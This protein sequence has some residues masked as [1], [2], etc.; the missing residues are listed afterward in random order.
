MV[1]NKRNTYNLEKR[2][3]YFCIIDM[4]FLPYIRFLSIKASMIIVAIWYINGGFKKAFTKKSFNRFLIFML[5]SFTS[6]LLGIILNYQMH[7]FKYILISNSTILLITWFSYLY[8]YYYRYNFRRYEI[9]LEKI[10]IL[11][12]LFAFMSAVL[13][14][15]EPQLFYNIRRF[16]TLGNEEITFLGSAYT[17]FMH[18]ASEPNN[19]SAMIIAIVAY[20]KYVEE[21]SGM[22]MFYIYIISFVIVVITMSTTGILMFVLLAIFGLLNLHKPVKKI[23]IN[24]ILLI[25]MSF[26]ILIFVSIFFDNPLMSFLKSDAF[27]TAQFRYNSYLEKGNYS[28]SRVSIW[29]NLISSINILWYIIIGRGTN[30]ISNGISYRPHN[31]HLLLIYGYG[32]IAYFIFMFDF[33]IPRKNIMKKKYIA[34]TLPFLIIFTMNTM[35]GDL[36]CVF[37]F[38]LLLARVTSSN[39]NSELLVEE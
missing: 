1:E 7:G 29:T 36:R 9:K 15:K 19:F 16:W 34:V 17:R 25:L 28:G 30:I 5:L 8:L 39:L 21:I 2:L 23:K 35:L 26:F 14:L 37:L 22:K 13:F 10:L 24:R 18:I 3:F 32:M 27:S 20:L 12:L 4:L 38:V 33:F 31:G 11:Y 6:V